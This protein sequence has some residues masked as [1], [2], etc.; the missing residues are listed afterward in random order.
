MIRVTDIPSQIKKK[1]MLELTI[2]NPE[3]QKKRAMG[4]P[5]WGCPQHI[6]L[7]QEVG[8]ELILPR[9]YLRHLWML[10]GFSPSADNRVI[11][12]EVTY[13]STINLR[14][15]Q[16]PAID[17]V[18][19]SKQGVII[20]PCGAGKT[21]TGLAVLAN[22]KQPALWLTHTKDLLNQSLER[23]KARLN[24]KS[25]EYGV[26]AADEMSIGSHITFG[27]VQ[28]MAKRDL[29]QLVNR[30]GAIIIDECH[31][32][33]V[34]AKSVAMF[35]GVIA[36]FPAKYRIGLTATASRSDGLIETM[37]A[38]IGPII[39]QVQ[40]ETLNSAGNVIAPEIEVV[41]TN[42]VFEDEEPDPNKRFRLMLNQMQE[43][44]ERNELIV[45]K[46]DQSAP[47]SPEQQPF[48]Y[49][50][51]LGDGIK[52]LKK[53]CSMLQDE[54]QTSLG[55]PVA[56]CAFVCGETKKIDREKIM[57]DVRAGKIHY[58]FATYSLAKE[59]LDIPQ[60]NRLYFVTPKRDKAT[61]QQAVGRIMRK[62]P[63][64]TE[65]IVY[66]FLDINVVTCINQF[67]ERKRVYKA[68]GAK[69]NKPEV[70]K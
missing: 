13:N 40:Q 32:C 15:Y 57:S 12:P 49:G 21:E 1:V 52:H 41:N 3:Y 37:F 59:G 42:F 5:I 33:F 46:I 10:Q 47:Y 63:G 23:A 69:I 44:E 67:S 51:I 16:S 56:K 36:Q 26:I 61:I 35:N 17:A 70:I 60:L 45:D 31:H 34:N 14:D 29:S 20:M 19:K 9:G 43:D 50:L 25:G 24:L 11:L 2:K 54:L 30:F 6:R 55:F 18:G 48:N 65:A 68:L 53:L 58:L 38:T 28:T 64:K 8:Q 7:Y 39:Y 62:S 27:M 22:L 66:D 4:L